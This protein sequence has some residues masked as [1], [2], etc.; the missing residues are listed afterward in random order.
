MDPIFLRPVNWIMK[1]SNTFN[2]LGYNSDGQRVY[3]KFMKSSVSSWTDFFITNKIT[4]YDWIK[5][6]KYRP[7]TY[8]HEYAVINIMALETTSLSIDDVS[9]TLRLMFR[10][11]KSAI[12]SFDRDVIY[13]SDVGV[14]NVFK[15]DRII[16]IGDIEKYVSLYHEYIPSDISIITKILLKREPK[17]D[18]E[19][20]EC[21]KQLWIGFDVLNTLEKVANDLDCTVDTILSQ[22]VTDFLSLKNRR[23]SAT[24]PSIPIIPGKYENVFIYDYSELYRELLLQSDRPETVDLADRL[25]SAPPC[26]KREV[27]FHQ[28]HYQ[29]RL[30][31]ICMTKL[32]ELTAHTIYLDSLYIYTTEPIDRRYLNLTMIVPVCEI[33]EAHQIQINGTVETIKS[34]GNSLSTCTN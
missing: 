29:Y 8:Q 25:E 24:Y 5:I 18:L 21:M 26:F 34:S 30:E 27:F 32:N 16:G 9:I 33:N 4:P 7:T 11:K 20:V 14:I 3:V 6:S 15:P 22:N 12:T 13:D 1:K 23:L 17:S 28:P 2:V 19:V 31:K 10:Y